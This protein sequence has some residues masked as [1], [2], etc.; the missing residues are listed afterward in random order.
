MAMQARTALV[1]GATGLVGNQL[2]EQLLANDQFSAVVIFVRRTTGLQ[3]NKLREHIISF[4]QP[5]SWDHL[6]KGDVLFSALGTTL[7]QAGSK[8]TQFK[9]DFTYQYQFAEVAAT[10]GIATYVLVSSAGAN[11]K[12]SFFICA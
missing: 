5:E 3:H 1:I 8:E 10:N 11:E 6:V 7:K 2:V 9:V 4:E 12:A